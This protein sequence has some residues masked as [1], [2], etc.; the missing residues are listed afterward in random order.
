MHSF[1]DVSIG[2]GDDATMMCC[3]VFHRQGKGGHQM[4]SAR[5]KSHRTH[6]TNYQQHSPA[7]LNHC[8]QPADAAHAV[9]AGAFM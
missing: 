8:E 5:M 4:H 9:L 2:I 1:I 7:A 3:V 6:H